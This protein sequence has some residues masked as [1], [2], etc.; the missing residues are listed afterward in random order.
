MKFNKLF[1]SLKRAVQTPKVFSI[2][3][4]DQ[5]TDR[6]V[7]AHTAAYSLEEALEKC[8]ADLKEKGHEVKG[9]KVDMFAHSKVEN[10]LGDYINPNMEKEMNPVS[11]LMMQIVEGK[12]FA[13]FEENKELFTDSQKKYIED[14]LEITKKK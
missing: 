11:F 10:L 14:K 7:L 4:I 6:R 12:D 13:L 2:V 3:F 9:N 5:S 1:N 8:R